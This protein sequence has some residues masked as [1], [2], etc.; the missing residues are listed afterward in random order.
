MSGPCCSWVLSMTYADPDFF[1][2]LWFSDESHIH[3]NGYIN[4]QITRFLEFKQ[5]DVVQKPLHSVWVTI[6]CTISG[7]GLLTP[8]FVEDDAQIP[9][10]VNQERYREIIIAPFV[11]ETFCRTRNLSL[12][13]Q[14]MQQDGAT[15]HMAGESLA[16]LQQHFGDRLISRGMEFSFLSQPPDL[17]APDSYIW[18]MLKESVFRSDNPPGNVSELLE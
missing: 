1:S 15:A 9:L 8:Y 12:W 4:W 2:N 17:T 11:L 18:G 13:W 7:H 6:W 10:T 14:W 16:C 3:L 5:H